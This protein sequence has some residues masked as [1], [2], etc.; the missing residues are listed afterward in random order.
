MTSKWTLIAKTVEDHITLNKGEKKD[1]LITR[2]SK[3]K[4]NW[5]N[6]AKIVN[7]HKIKN[8]TQNTVIRRLL[9]IKSGKITSLSQISGG[10]S[11]SNSGSSSSSS[12]SSDSSSSSGG[13]TDSS[14]NS[15]G[16][17]G[18]SSSSGGSGT[19]KKVPITDPQKA[20]DFALREW[21]KIKR[22]SG[23][24][25]E[26][27]VFGN[28]NWKTGEW[29]KVYIPSLNEY[30][31]MYITKVDHSNSSDSEWLTNIT[32][33]DYAPSLSE[34]E[35]EE[36]EEDD[37]STSG[38]GTTDGSTDS[39]GSSDGSSIWTEVAKI[40]QEN[41]ESN[42]WDSFIRSVVDAKSWDEIKTKVVGHKQKNNK[43]YADVIQDLCKVK[44]ISY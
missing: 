38:D 10:G 27:Q 3:A 20:M 34:P 21:N 35:E 7:G 1:T 31:D 9:D 42:D 17:D 22:T 43:S 40:L 18:S 13:G 30:I 2:I 5:S 24:T 33:M 8:G 28:N 23:H 4:N 29:C 39:D 14:D 15:S 37:E 36:E 11:S 16:G 6:V 12:G 41:Y 19:V 32:L 44:G 26:T 25:L